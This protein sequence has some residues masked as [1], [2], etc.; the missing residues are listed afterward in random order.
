MGSFLQKCSIFSGMHN[1][2]KTYFSLE[3]HASYLLVPLTTATDTLYVKSQ[4]I[5][6]EHSV[7]M[8][9]VLITTVH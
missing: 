9:G 5:I 8:H 2:M 7:N 6:I 4:F 3:G 1:K